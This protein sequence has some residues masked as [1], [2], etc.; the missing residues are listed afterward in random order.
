MATST[1]IALPEDL[2]AAIQ[3]AADAENRTLDD[4]LADAVRRYLDERSWGELLSYGAERAN[5]LG[6]T[7]SDVDR[8]IAE[9]RAEQR[10]S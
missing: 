6:I 8:L 10:R 4:L 1:R 7:E 3:F 5:A 2:L 9:S